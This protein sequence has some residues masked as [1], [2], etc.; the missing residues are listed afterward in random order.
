MEKI[1]KMGLLGATALIGAG[2]A[3]MSEERI[4]EFVKTRVNEGAISKEEGKVL[5]EDLVS[6]TRKQRL[7][8][9]K[10]VV[11]RL[12]STLQTADKELADYADSIDEMKIRELEGEL[13]KM[14]SLR[15]GDK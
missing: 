6:E 14:K 7:N 1:K 12:H 11:E 13:E 3:A 9:E 2:L 4:R 15:K 10:N 8:L 5:V